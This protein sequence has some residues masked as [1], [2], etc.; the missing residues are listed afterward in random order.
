VVTQG[1]LGRIAD[2]SVARKQ[3][4]QPGEVRL[5]Q[6]AVG[7]SMTI[8][9]SAPDEDVTCYRVDVDSGSIRDAIRPREFRSSRL[10]EHL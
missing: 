3:S 4:L 9:P 10:N 2:T 6:V 7:L 5:G 8:R 1:W